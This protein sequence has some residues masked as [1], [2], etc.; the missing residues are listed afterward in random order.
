M[1]VGQSAIDPSSVLTPNAGNLPSVLLQLPKWVKEH[2][3]F[4]E[5][6]RTIFPTIHS[7]VSGP[8]SN[9]QTRISVIN[10]GSDGPNTLPGAFVDLDDSGTGISQVLAILYVAVTSSTRGLSL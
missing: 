5:H 9:I 4:I 3:K 10:N 7:V 6:V 8:I 2:S 1:N